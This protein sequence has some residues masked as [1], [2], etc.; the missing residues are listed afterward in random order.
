MKVLIDTH[1]FLWFINGDRQL[2]RRARE[3]I[4]D[5][6]NERTI[7]IVSLWEIAIKIRIDKMRLTE[8]FDDLIPAELHRNVIDV[9]EF[10]IAHVSLVAQAIVE[11]LPVLSVDPVF[12][13]YG[14]NRLW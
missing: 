4:E 6:E 13:A 3:I 8:P 1:T 14:V 10:N 7:S 9:L 5:L 12:D 2:S 11:R